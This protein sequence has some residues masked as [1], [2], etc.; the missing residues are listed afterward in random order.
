MQ[1]KMKRLILLIMLVCLATSFI[2]CGKDEVP[3]SEGQDVVLKDNQNVESTDDK[4][5]TE[6]NNVT[7]NDNME[8]DYIGAMCYDYS[9]ENQWIEEHLG[10]HFTMNQDE[11]IVV[12]VFYDSENN[13]SVEKVIEYVNK[14]T[15]AHAAAYVS[16]TGLCLGGDIVVTSSENVTVNDLECMRFEGNTPNETS[17]RDVD[18]GEII[19]SEWDAYVYGYTFLVDNKS[20]AVIGI[21]TP[22]EQEQSM[23]D[24]M[25]QQ[26][27]DI[28]A[29][30][31]DE[32]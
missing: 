19:S 13:S 16:R 22:E 14:Y 5:D 8:V 12:G 4:D 10:T 18:T 1:T 26:V 15:F 24:E 11:N 7:E 31:R 20:Y 6:T 32:K 3:E 23:I 28:M 17:Y 27:D 9:A 30:M 2:A 25:K 29:S 21:V